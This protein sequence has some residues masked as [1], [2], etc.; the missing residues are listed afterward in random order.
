MEKQNSTSIS[1][2]GYENKEKTHPS[3]VSRKCC[4]EK[5]VDFIIN[6][7]RQDTMFL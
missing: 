7:R 4:V 5:H 2:F 1:E 3:Y 6:T